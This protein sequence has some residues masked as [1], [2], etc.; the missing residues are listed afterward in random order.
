MDISDET[1]IFGTNVNGM[2][3][4]YPHMFEVRGEAGKETGPSV[5]GKLR[6]SWTPKT[7]S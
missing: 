4:F 5:R 2:C 3:V 7:P 1:S 6:T